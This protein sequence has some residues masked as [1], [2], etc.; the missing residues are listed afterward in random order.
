M[1][2]KHI[3]SVLNALAYGTDTEIDDT[4]CIICG[5]P[6]NNVFFPIWTD[7]QPWPVL[8][9]HDHCYKQY[10]LDSTS[11]EARNLQNV[12]AYAR[13]SKYVF[14]V[15]YQA[16]NVR[17]YLPASVCMRVEEV[18]TSIQE[19]IPIDHEEKCVFCNAFDFRAH[20]RLLFLHY[21]V[22]RT[23]RAHNSCFALYLGQY[24][25]A[26]QL[27]EF[28]T[29]QGP[30]FLAEFNKIYSPTNLIII[31]KKIQEGA[32]SVLQSDVANMT[33][34]EKLQYVEYLKRQGQKKDS[35]DFAM[36]KQWLSLAESVESS[37]RTK[38]KQKKSKS[39]SKSNSRNKSKSN[40]NS[41]NKSKSNSNS[42]NKSKS[43]SNSRNKSKSNSNSRNK[44][45]SE[46]SRHVANMELVA[47]GD[48]KCTISPVP[49]R[50]LKEGGWKPSQWDYT[51]L[52]LP[53]TKTNLDV[54]PL[55]LSS[56]LEK[57][58]PR[59]DICVYKTTKCQLTEE[60]MG[61]IRKLRNSPFPSSL[62]YVTEKH[63]ITCYQVISN[64]LSDALALPPM[65]IEKVYL[66]IAITIRKLGQH[67]VFQNDADLTNVLLDSE[68]YYYARPRLIDWGY[69]M[70]VD[71]RSK[72][73][74]HTDPTNNTYSLFGIVNEC[75]TYFPNIVWDGQPPT[76]KSTQ[77]EL[78][79]FVRKNWAALCLFSFHWLILRIRAAENYDHPDE[80]R[81]FASLS[82]FGK[83]M[84]RAS[85]ISSLIDGMGQVLAGAKPETIEINP[86]EEEEAI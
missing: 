58:D 49:S 3:L 39:K 66:Q 62:G 84:S 1:S 63:G 76:K 2:R 22:E 43:N 51:L 42:R 35:D 55:N 68:R 12:V 64:H 34:K 70:W 17:Q 31:D 60:E 10:L 6:R 14:D 21:P 69:A 40:S 29:K 72:T 61:S 23:L 52:L 36:R 7:F 57:I 75:E 46:S 18:V 54:V 79:E 81:L 5:E 15:L 85:S 19:N 48:E 86:V 73:L 71:K 32:E 65:F 8:Y 67:L 13:M 44:S 24:A 37:M 30:D 47:C 59:E 53:H 83:M 25:A 28:A 56:L 45:K 20:I 74:H 50:C 27:V 11:K 33:K 82:T 4:L 41:R 38:T 77:L 78:V 16:E 9:I 80:K 26:Q